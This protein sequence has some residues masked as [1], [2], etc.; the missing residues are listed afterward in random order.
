MNEMYK[1]QLINTTTNEVVC[2]TPT[3]S[4]NFNLMIS[5]EKHVTR[6]GFMQ[7]NEKT[8]CRNEIY[9][10][11]IE[12]LKVVYKDE[13]SHVNTKKILVTVDTLWEPTEKANKN[14]KWHCEIKRLS[15]R[16]KIWSGFDFE[17][18]LRQH[19]LEEW[20]REQ[21]HA[22]VLSQLLRIDALEGYIIKYTEDH[23]SKITATFGQGYLHAG[24]HLAYD[25]L[26]SK[27]DLKAFAA[28]NTQFDL[29]SEINKRAAEQEE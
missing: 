5:G 20:S 18:K 15:G 24:K 25:V 16:E 28:P 19:W 26:E 12:K 3:A 10:A 23:A 4:P 8:E 2:E 7:L 29:I 22:A 9:H 14:S 27:I 17:L 1:H 11:L 6:M 13:L 21:I